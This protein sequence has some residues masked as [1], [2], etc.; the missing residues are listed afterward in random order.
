MLWEDL[1]E[2]E[3]EE[4]IA[5]SKGLCVLPVGCLEKHGQHLPL[6]TD[7][8]IAR[9][10]V[11][12]AVKDEDAVVF[13]L[14]FWLGDVA[15][16]HSNKNPEKSRKLGYIGINIRTMLRTLEELCDEIARNGFDKIL[17]LSA[18][19]GNVSLFTTLVRQLERKEKPYKVFYSTVGNNSVLQPEIF[20]KQITE[21]P[22]KFPMITDTDIAVMKSWIPTGYQGGHA[23]FLE[24]ADVMAT[25][26]HLVAP[27]RYYAENGINNHRTDYMTVLGINIKDDWSCRY[28]NAYSGAAPHGCS[29]SIG[30]AMLKLH[31]ERVVRVLR[32]IKEF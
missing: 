19:G 31:V 11:L 15:S 25:R 32:A 5:R 17:M 12:D 23:N 14:G 22:E 20:V 8:F 26:P 16:S 7:Y 29:Q 18:H 10:I 4:A 30:Q 24:T 6:G 2:E 21:D 1:Q 27:D 9:D 28:P 3:F 13:P